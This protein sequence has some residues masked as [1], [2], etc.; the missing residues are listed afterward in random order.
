[1]TRA[2]QSIIYVTVGAFVL[3]VIG[4]AAT[5]RGLFTAAFGLSVTGLKQGHLW[6]LVT[7]LLVHG[8][9][10]HILLNMLGLY[11]IGP[12][13]ERA[14]GTRQFYILYLLSGVLG[15]VGWLLISDT[16]WAVC[17]GASGALF[18][19]LGAFAALFP[20]RMI[21]LLVFFVL[22]VT[23]KAWVLAVSLAGVELLFLLSSPGGGIAYSAHL[24]GGIAGYLY[25]TIV[26]RRGGAGARFDLS[27]VRTMLAGWRSPAS[28]QEIDRV[29]DKV[30]REGIHSLTRRERETLERASRERT[31][32]GT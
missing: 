8:G 22:P 16:P 17:I 28:E 13:T 31:G 12:E 14:I 23:M 6:Q 3:Q 15:G 25:A 5:T 1:M 32:R 27:R 18:G 21:T 24:A 7:Y 26:F 20:N 10:F 9:V 19:I 30:S 29:L 4:D 2:V 11:F